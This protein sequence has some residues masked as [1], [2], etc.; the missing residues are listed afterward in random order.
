MSVSVS[1]FPTPKIVVSVSVSEKPTPKNVGVGVDFD[2]DTDTDTDTGVG[3][4]GKTI[5]NSRGLVRN[6]D[7]SRLIVI[8]I[9]NPIISGSGKGVS[10]LGILTGEDT[11]V[12]IKCV[13]AGE[14]WEVVCLDESIRD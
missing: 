5:I 10:D 12:F 2:T 9:Q 6:N 11:T 13:N 1:D 7:S 4:G 14:G 8:N 3:V